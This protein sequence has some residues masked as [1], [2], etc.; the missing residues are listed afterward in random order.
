MNAQTLTQPPTTP[1][2]T[3]ERTV[4]D[5]VDMVNRRKIPFLIAT[6]LVLTFALGLAFG[7]PPVYRSS[8]VILIEQQE[9]PED[10]VKSTITTY[11]DQR[12]QEISRRVLS[13]ASLAALIDKHRLYASYRERFGK[14]ALVA[15]MKKSIQL[16]MASAQIAKGRGINRKHPNFVF[17][18][19]FDYPKSAEVAQKITGELTNLFLKENESDRK[20]SSEGT[21]QFLLGELK[22]QQDRAAEIDLKIA[23][24]KRKNSGMLPEQAELNLRVAD[25]L[26]ADIKEVDRQLFDLRQQN[27][28][29]R[30]DLAKVN[31]FMTAPT[32]TNDLGEKVMS[33]DARIQVLKSTYVTLLSKYSP[34]HPKLKKIEKE[35]VRLGGDI[36]FSGQ[37]RD[38]YSELAQRQEELASLKTNSSP[39]DPEISR[40]EN[41]VRRIKSRIGV[42][43]ASDNTVSAPEFHKEINPAYLSITTQL[44]VNEVT[45]QSLEK[46]KAQLRA[47]RNEVEGSLMKSP[48]VEMKYNQLRR[49]YQAVQKRIAN[50]QAK[51][52]TAEMSEKLESSQNAERLTIIEPPNLP[53]APIK[54]KRRVILLLGLLFALGVGFAVVYLIESLDRSVY[55]NRVM[56]EITGVQPLSVIPYVPPEAGQPGARRQQLRRLARWGAPVIAFAIVILLIQ[57]NLLP[58]NALWGAVVHEL[59]MMS[60]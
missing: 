15:K 58:L 28:V 19:S 35:I 23:N 52:N 30:S 36:A 27:I 37:V 9:I 60:F 21:Y 55:N 50:I 22:R 3:R 38:A 17:N 33:A 39:D 1:A 16:K 29:L 59:D 34:E 13:N 40:L 24:F 48:L 42:L 8:A 46:K 49:D 44:K 10:L 14:P 53:G 5:Y 31:K 41:E 47:Q 26:D 11:A 12:I 20:R 18:L 43:A 7:L 45:I 4:L 25:R 2:P 6:A 51:L 54:P 56:A 32:L 57:S